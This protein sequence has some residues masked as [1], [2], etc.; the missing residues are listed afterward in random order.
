[1]GT[2]ESVSIPGHWVPERTVGAGTGFGAYPALIAKFESKLAG[3]YPELLPRASE[4]A[5]LALEEAAAGRLLDPEQALPVYLRDDV[6]R[7][8]GPGH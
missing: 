2:P 4:I 3:V 5:T 1:V 6:A 8:P 7:P